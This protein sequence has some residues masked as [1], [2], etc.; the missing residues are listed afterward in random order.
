MLI[1]PTTPCAQTRSQPVLANLARR[2][3]RST[4]VRFMLSLRQVAAAATLVAL[5]STLAGCGGDDSKDDASDK[6]TKT[7]T[8]SP[9]PT[10]TA[11]TESTS[12]SDTTSATPMDPT[13]DVTQEQVDAAL[14]TPEEVGADFVA[15]TY[16]D[17]DDPPPCDPS[18]TPIDEAVP[19]QVQGGTEIDHTSG[20]L[21][22]QEEISIYADDAT[23]ANAFTLGVSGLTCSD[24]TLSDGSTVSLEAPQ[25]VTAQVDTSGLSSSTA[26]SFSGDG[27]EGVLIVTLASRVIMTTT[28]QGATGADTSGVT[29][30]VDLAA[31]A[32]AKALAN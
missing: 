20:Q 3:R 25:D 8:P 10:E 4:S 32:F 28:F 24:G 7:V 6:V 2:T 30:P 21:A 26:Y 11:T 27:F 5:A 14:L 22:M 1:G 12:P 17:T 16:T 19:P 23:A 18:G 13:G 15:G 29:A 9:S 31:A